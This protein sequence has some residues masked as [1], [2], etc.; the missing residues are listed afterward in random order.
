MSRTLE[1]LDT[2]LNFRFLMC[3]MAAL[4]L[5]GVSASHAGTVPT[6][7]AESA[8]FQSATS[9]SGSTNDPDLEEEDEEPDCE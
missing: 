5:G 1:L 8:A 4:A 2:V 6:Q 9:E 7:L 3:F